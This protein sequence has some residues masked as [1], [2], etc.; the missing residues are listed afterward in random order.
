MSVSPLGS[1]ANPPCLTPAGS[2]GGSTPRSVTPALLVQ[3]SLSFHLDPY[4][5]VPRRLV[6]TQSDMDELQ[7]HMRAWSARVLGQTY[8]SEPLSL[9]VK[10]R[11]VVLGRLTHWSWSEEPCNLPHCP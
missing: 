10:G 1:G 2:G 11:P 4:R 8:P 7:A 3:L 9:L 6:V 5:G